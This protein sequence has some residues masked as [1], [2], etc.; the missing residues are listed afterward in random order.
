[1]RVRH[2]YL[3]AAALAAVLLTAL[4]TPSALAAA[5]SVLTTSGTNVAVGDAITS[6]GTATV[7]I[8]SSTTTSTVTCPFSFSGS[9]QTNPTAPGTATA[10]VE[11]MALPNCGGQFVGLPYAMSIASGSRPTVQL[12]ANAS[13]GIELDINVPTGF[14]MTMCG[15]RTTTLTGTVSN[16]G[17]VQFV[18]PLSATDTSPPAPCGHS[19]SF[20]ASFSHLVDATLGQPMTVN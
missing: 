7:T 5:T 20:S 17:S 12:T 14:G 6:S 9:V 2:R 13:N 1:M 4:A 8:M 11:S 16:T 10:S 19:V 15:Y 3:T 18:G